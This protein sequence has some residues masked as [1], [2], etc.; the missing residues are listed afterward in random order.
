MK[1]VD[2]QKCNERVC[3]VGS[4][5]K[6]NV[7]CKLVSN[8]TDRIV[9]LCLNARDIRNVV[10]VCVYILYILCSDGGQLL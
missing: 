8:V 5:P 2:F 10:C 9:I 1:S 4:H 7:W 6:A 3:D